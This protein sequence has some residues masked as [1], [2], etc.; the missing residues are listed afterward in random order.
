MTRIAPARYT[1]RRKA[2][3]TPAILGALALAV[4]AIVLGAMRRG[5]Y[6]VWLR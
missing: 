6:P 3:R 1:R 4:A 2:R 5:I